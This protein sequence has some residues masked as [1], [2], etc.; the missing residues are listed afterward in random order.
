MNEDGASDHIGIVSDGTVSGRHTVI[1]NHPD[2]GHIADE[3]KIYRWK[4][5]GH[6]RVKDS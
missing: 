5:T 4:I 2:P 3:D 6:Y 1:H